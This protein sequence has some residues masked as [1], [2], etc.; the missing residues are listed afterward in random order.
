MNAVALSRSPLFDTT[1]TLGEAGAQELW[2]AKLKDGLKEN[3]ISKIESRE[4][5]D[6]TVSSSWSP[7]DLLKFRRVEVR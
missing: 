4:S 6:S 5:L 2:L 1:N 7:S 3:S